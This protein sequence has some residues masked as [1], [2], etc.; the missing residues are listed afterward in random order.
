MTVRHVFVDSNI[1]IYAHDIHA[2]DKHEIAKN[3]IKDFW[4]CDVHPS[5]S[6]QVL[7]EC[8][9]NL[10]RKNIPEKAASETILDYLKWNVIVNDQAILLEGI[11]LKEKYKFSFWDALIVAAAKQAKADVILSEDFSPHQEYEGMKVINP[12]HEAPRL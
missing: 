8:Y 7:Q 5:I 2:K 9:V 11:F 6:V 1:L 10:I 3:K 4:Q 12:F